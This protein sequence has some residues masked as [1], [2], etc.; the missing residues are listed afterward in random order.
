MG[1]AKRTGTWAGAGG[2]GGTCTSPSFPVACPPP[3]SAH[4][5]VWLWVVSSFPTCHRK[6]KPAPSMW[7]LAGCHT[8]SHQ[9]KE[10]RLR[11]LALYAV[12]SRADKPQR[13]NLGGGPKDTDTAT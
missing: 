8:Q 3:T 1:R 11:P 13:R 4:S 9:Q 6:F 10:R 2:G 7:R 12:V 5:R